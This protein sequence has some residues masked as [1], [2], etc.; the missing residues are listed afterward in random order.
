MHHTHL[1]V[2]IIDTRALRVWRLVER[3]QPGT[4]EP[5]YCP[6]TVCLHGCWWTTNKMS[7]ENAI[8]PAQIAA[9]NNYLYVCVPGM[10]LMKAVSPQ[11]HCVCVLS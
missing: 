1:V 9:I 6:Y 11:H 2:E 5:G 3:R 10:L 7:S 4:I 8:W